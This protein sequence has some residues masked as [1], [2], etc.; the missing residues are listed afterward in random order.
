MNVLFAQIIGTTISVAGGALLALLIER[1]KGRRSAR[2]GEVRALRLLVAEIASRRMF[3]AREARDVLSLDRA[4]PESDLNRV[5]R[6]VLSLRRQIRAARAELRFDSSV[7]EPL[8]QMIAACNLFI[9]NVDDRADDLLGEIETL[10]LGVDG[11][12]AELCL[13][14]PRELRYREPGSAAYRL[15]GAVGAITPSRGRLYP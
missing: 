2:L 6:S 9:A 15:E 12:L 1:S 10:R 8:E 11:L 5:M 7:W 3:A 4:D 14:H 13:A